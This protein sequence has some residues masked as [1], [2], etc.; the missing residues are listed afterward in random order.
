MYKE[1]ELLVLD[2]DGT[3]TDGIYQVDKDGYV[4][5]SFYTRDFDAMTRVMEAGIMILILTAS[6]DHVIHKQVG[7][8]R[9]HSERWSKWYNEELI[10]A[11]GATSKVLVVDNFLRSRDLEWSN[12]AYMGD[13]ENDLE[14]MELAGVTACPTDAVP[15]I[16]DDVT[17]P[18]DYY[19]GKGAVHDFCTHILAQKKKENK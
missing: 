6:H 8:I 2:V 1:I 11:I 13:A 3:L 9:N 17:Y 5:K 18:S 7:R 14:C 15:Q 10:I 16:R 12:V 4:I 19:G